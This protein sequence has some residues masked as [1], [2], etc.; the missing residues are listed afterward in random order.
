MGTYAKKST[1]I[2]E[3]QSR[4]VREDN[5][6]GI[7][8]N[9]TMDNET[10]SVLKEIRDLQKEANEFRNKAMETVKVQQKGVSRRIAVL[11]AVLFIV[12]FIAYLLK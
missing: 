11:F 4:C 2:G 5:T 10:L 12:M 9:Q 1:D 3:I 6:E 8:Q 7:C